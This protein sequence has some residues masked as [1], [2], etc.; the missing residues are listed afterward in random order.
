MTLFIEKLQNR[1]MK[2]PAM[3][4]LIDMF[5]HKRTE[6]YFY[7]Y[8]PGLKR[9]APKIHQQL[10]NQDISLGAIYGVEGA[11]PEEAL[12]IEDMKNNEIIFEACATTLLELPKAF[13][14]KFLKKHRVL[15]HDYMEGGRFPIENFHLLSWVR[16]LDII[17][18]EIYVC[19]SGM[20]E[21]KDLSLNVKPFCIPTWAIVTRANTLYDKPE[22][23]WHEKKRFAVVPIHKPRI[24]R[25]ILLSELDRA[26]LLKHCDWSCS[27][28]MDDKYTERG[29]FERSPSLKSMMGWIDEK[30]PPYVQHFIKKYYALGELPRKIDDVTD[31]WLATPP[32]KDWINKYRWYISAETIVN[33]RGGDGS[34]RASFPTEKTFKGMMLGAGLIT[35]AGNGFDQYLE[36]MGFKIPYHANLINDGYEAVQGRARSIALLLQADVD[37]Q[38]VKECAEINYELMWDDDFLVRLTCNPLN[39]LKTKNP[40]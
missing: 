21:T 32:P 18:K 19:T 40:S 26:D 11:T 14:R 8:M 4:G 1:A 13:V 39:K 12:G 20:Y 37:W 33:E 22:F 16:S 2:T 10:S 23:N 38:W 30:A 34:P 27:V 5:M 9:F 7:P 15:I 31:F 29:D 17:P 25:L 6:Y 36:D 24:P 3:P 28:V 35:L